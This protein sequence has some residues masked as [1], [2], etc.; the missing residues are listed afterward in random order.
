MAPWEHWLG[1][2][3]ERDPVLGCRRL[4]LKESGDSDLGTGHMRNWAK[5]LPAVW[6][7]QV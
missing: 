4:T 3:R 5:N 7:T 1:R 6:E 2:S